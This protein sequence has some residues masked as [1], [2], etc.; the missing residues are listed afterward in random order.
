GRATRFA[1]QV[2]AERVGSGDRTVLLVNNVEDRETY[3]LASVSGLAQTLKGLASRMHLNDDVLVLF[4]T[5]HGSQDG[6]EVENG[7]LPLSQLA[8][9]DL[10]H[11]LDDSR[12]RWRSVVM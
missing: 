8:P 10:R 2:F 6:L 4:L 3:P 7:S 5:S 9:G 1:S 11:A 12:I